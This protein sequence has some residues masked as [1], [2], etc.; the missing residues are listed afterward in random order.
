MCDSENQIPKKSKRKNNRNVSRKKRKINHL[1]KKNKKKIILNKINL[2]DSLKLNKKLIKMTL[3]QNSILMICSTFNLYFIQINKFN[4]HKIKTQ[5]IPFPINCIFE[6]KNGKIIITEKNSIIIYSSIYHLINNFN[7]PSQIINEHMNFINNII[8]FK[9]ENFASSSYDGIINFWKN[10]SEFFILNYSLNN[11]NFKF[12]SIFSLKNMKMILLN[13]S[14]LIFFNLEERKITKMIK[15]FYII[16]SIKELNDNIIL[17]LSKRIIFFIDGKNEQIKLSF[18]L[19][20]SF[21]N[22]ALYENKLFIVKN[23]E[24]N[25]YIYSDMDNL[26]F[27]NKITLEE[28]EFIDY[29]F[30]NNKYILIG[31]KDLSCIQIYK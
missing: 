12:D 4:L 7:F 10:D 27:E 9:N 18:D 17:G 30:V 22:F 2:L 5:K 13:E 29:L 8:E 15:L 14:H 24:I 6:L 11:L 23:N 25:E 31:S 26:K 20:L 16:Y 28:I 3:I 19:G 1:I 21:N